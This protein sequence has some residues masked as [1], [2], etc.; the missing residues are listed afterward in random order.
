MGL[1]SG[2][3]VLAFFENKTARLNAGIVP[4]PRALAKLQRFAFSG[5]PDIGGTVLRNGFA[6][7]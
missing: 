6:A 3:Y 5:S 1:G 2:Y 7:V 4:K